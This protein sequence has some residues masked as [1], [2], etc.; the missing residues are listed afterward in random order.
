MLDFSSHEKIIV[1]FRY[2]ARDNAKIKTKQIWRYGI[3]IF[4]FFQSCFFA[5]SVIIVC[6]EAIL[7]S[8]QTGEAFLYNN[9][10]TLILL[11]I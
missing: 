8:K 5:I 7:Y 9:I 2:Q 1:I 4:I 6:T 10:K 3:I 11:L